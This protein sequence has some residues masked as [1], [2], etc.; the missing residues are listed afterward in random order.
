MRKRG[1]IVGINI[2]NKN[3]E[4][5]P[6]KWAKKLKYRIKYVKLQNRIKF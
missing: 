6:K 4:L 3:S 5:I 2:N 1:I